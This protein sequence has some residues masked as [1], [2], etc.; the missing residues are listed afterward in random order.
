MDHRGYGGLRCGGMGVQGVE[1]ADKGFVL[2]E[3]TDD[4]TKDVAASL[5]QAEGFRSVDLVTRPYDV[6]AIIE[7]EDLVDIKPRFTTD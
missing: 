4:K 2:K 5:R 1:M 7:G 6:T 3:T